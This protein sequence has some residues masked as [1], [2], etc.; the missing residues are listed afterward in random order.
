MFLYL[1]LQILVLGDNYDVCLF[2]G[3]YH[4]SAFTK[5]HKCGL[6]AGIRLKEGLSLSHTHTLTNP[7]M[8]VIV[9]SLNPINGQVQV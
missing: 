1:T 6:S 9:L 3:L 7:D 4:N 8:H 5:G 2:Q